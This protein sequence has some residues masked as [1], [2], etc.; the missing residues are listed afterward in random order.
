MG[1]KY[2]NNRGKNIGKNKRTGEPHMS[3]L[4]VSKVNVNFGEM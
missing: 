4:Y 3:S 2:G 1:N